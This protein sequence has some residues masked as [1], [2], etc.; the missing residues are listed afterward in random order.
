MQC[1][2]GQCH[3]DHVMLMPVSMAYP[4]QTSHV[5]PHF[6]YLDLRNAMVVLMM[7]SSSYYAN[8]NGVT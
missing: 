1:F 5:A 4:G 6:D 2:Y 7:P 3:W 8:D